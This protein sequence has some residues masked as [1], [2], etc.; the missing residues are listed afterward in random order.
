MKD[1]RIIVGNCGAAIT[2]DLEHVDE[3]GGWSNLKINIQ[4]RCD[5]AFDST[6]SIN[7]VDS[8]ELFALSKRLTELAHELHKEEQVRTY[9]ALK[10]KF[11]PAKSE[12]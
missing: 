8:S 12:V 11:E 4:Q 9:K 1:N 3:Y 10:E 6:I 7:T 2:I 5:A